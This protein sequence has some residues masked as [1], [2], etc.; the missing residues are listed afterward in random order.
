MSVPLAAGKIARVM[1][2][3]LA[4]LT[5]EAEPESNKGCVAPGAAMRIR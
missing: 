5:P 1:T 4:K 3:R 2:E